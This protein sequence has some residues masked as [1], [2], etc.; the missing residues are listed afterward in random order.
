MK[1]TGIALMAALMAALTGSAAQA[2]DVVLAW[3]PSGALDMTAQ[4]TTP[5]GC[6]FAANAQL[7]PPEDLPDIDNTIVI[8][9]GVK[10]QGDVCP[11]EITVLDYHLTVPRV[12]KG[13]T[14]IIV[15]ETW[16]Q[17]HTIKATAYRLPPHK[18]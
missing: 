16:P 15:Y 13:T 14:A 4:I 1:K 8:T 12:P 17:A 2:A 7:G 10:A 5:N 9:L 18:K 11:Q 6:Y 3:T